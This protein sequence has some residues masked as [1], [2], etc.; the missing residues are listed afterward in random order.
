MATAALYCVYLYFMFSVTISDS[1]YSALPSAP[2]CPQDA[3][4]FSS[5]HA[6]GAGP[7]E[8]LVW[9]LEEH[10]GCRQTGHHRARWELVGRASTLSTWGRTG[11]WPSGNDTLGGAVSTQ[12]RVPP[13][14]V[15]RADLSASAGKHHTFCFLDAVPL[16]L[17]NS[18]VC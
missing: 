17:W 14:H 1:C 12:T 8:P 13:A 3:G 5:L 2:A 9:A 10:T 15:R 7:W 6:W 11:L 4:L 16:W 18:S